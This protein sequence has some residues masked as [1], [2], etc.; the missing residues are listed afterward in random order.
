MKSARSSL[1]RS[2]RLKS[3]KRK[4]DE[5]LLQTLREKN[6]LT[7]NQSKSCVLARLFD[8]SVIELQFKT[9]DYFVRRLDNEFKNPEFWTD[10]YYD[11][12]ISLV[13][14]ACRAAGMPKQFSIKAYVVE[15][16][17]PDPEKSV[18]YQLEFEA[19]KTE[20]SLQRIAASTDDRPI[21][22]YKGE[23]IEYW[24][25]CIREGF[26][27]ELMGYEIRY[28]KKKTFPSALNN[29]GDQFDRMFKR[30]R[31]DDDFSPVS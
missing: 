31:K 10:Q 26:L 7:E 6:K 4:V 22:V 27:G 30:D 17:H 3:K 20:E 8:N 12:F 9:Y 29:L 13:K 2:S 11:D 21:V 18:R 25:G 24:E 28:F 1:R 16:V 14:E 23:L 19:I 5:D 15:M